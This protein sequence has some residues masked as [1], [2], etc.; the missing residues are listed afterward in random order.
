M[1]RFC[2]FEFGFL[3]ILIKR[4]LGDPHC[5]LGHAWLLMEFGHISMVLFLIAVD[6]LDHQELE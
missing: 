5:L 6:V 4:H 1:P 3:D 2:T